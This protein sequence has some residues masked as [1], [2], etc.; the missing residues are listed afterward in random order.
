MPPVLLA[1]L[2]GAWQPGS[3]A[4]EVASGQ[5]LRVEGWIASRPSHRYS[6]G[7]ALL[8]VD[9]VRIVASDSLLD[10][11]NNARLVLRSKA[12]LPPYGSR[13]V[14]EGSYQAPRTPRNFHGWDERR[15][16][17]AQGAWGT[18]YARRF[19][20]RDG[21]GGPTWRRQIVEPLR[22]KLAELLRQTLNTMP[23]GLLTALI[24]GI[25]DELDP[26][27]RDSWRAL[28]MSH[29]L[30]LSGMHVGVVAAGLLA[31]VGSVR[32]RRGLALVVFGVFAYAAIGGLGSSVLRAALMI[33]GAA[34]AQYL[35][36][37]RHP[38]R[39]LGTA[40]LL[41]AATTPHR[42][43]DLGFQLSCSA[44][45]GILLCGAPLTRW[46][47]HQ[48]KRRWP[49]RLLAWGVATAG[50]GL[51][52]QITTLPWILAYFGFVSWI[53]PFTNLLLVPV[54]NLA[55]ILGLLG[56]VAALFVQ[57]VGRSLWLLSA[58]LLH[59]VSWLSLRIV[60]TIEPRVFLRGDAPVVLM[61]SLSAI[62]ALMMMAVSGRRRGSLA[63]LAVVFLCA[64]F[65]VGQR[66]DHP[67]WQLDMLD[68]G[69]GDAILL[70][71]GQHTWLID[72]GPSR[73]I[74]QGERTI[75]P[76]LRRE[77]ID[78]LRGVI[79]SHPH[80]DHYGGTAAVLRGIRVDTL[81]IAQ[82]SFDDP[83]YERW[84]QAIPSVPH[85]GLRAGDQLDMGSDTQAT[86]L[87]PPATDVLDSG[88]NGTSVSLWIRSPQA[89]DLL[90]MGD[91]EEDG[92]HELLEVWGEKLRAEATAFLILKAGHH[93]SNTSSSAA[94]L[95][96]IDAEMALISAGERN[97]YGHP[98][99]RTLEALQA[100]DCLILRTDRGGDIRLQQRARSLWVQRPVLRPQPIG[101]FATGAAIGGAMGAGPGPRA[102]LDAGIDA[103]RSPD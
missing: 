12:R 21:A 50:I 57:P 64:T 43:Y 101:T 9:S 20:R 33:T 44:T 103:A 74:D 61:A 98:S 60:E 56:A 41:L 15:S 80:Q 68:V 89:P 48:N 36:R 95:D 82:A 28:G 73:P 99:P 102:R 65:L 88:P 39:N 14:V 38:V 72:T 63:L 5:R 59:G 94:F 70:R 47:M 85:R 51:A 30:A 54:V 87:W 7:R 18:L 90:S 77:G 97:R 2:A 45:L 25:R 62:S 26:D 71:L 6:I 86:I 17:Q 92:E 32:R 76:H 27:L 10:I 52:A 53:S 67:H 31:M 66:Q 91:L 37:S 19:D 29:V 1:M 49:R 11:P 79:V 16:L 4:P 42:L 40:A 35:G 23:Q 84:R 100:R 34:L 46:A 75:L 3:V 13:I 83:V 24:L 22:T 78:H 58:G 55:L 81:Y 8:Q 96:A 69:Q 93:G